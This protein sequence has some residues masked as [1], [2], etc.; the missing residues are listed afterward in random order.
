[1]QDIRQVLDHHGLSCYT[2]AYV[3]GPDEEIYLISLFGS[4]SRVQAVRA[5]ILG[6]YPVYIQELGNLSWDSRKKAQRFT[7][8]K[9]QVWNRKLG[10]DVVHT[11]ALAPAVLSPE[12]PSGE[13][14]WLGYKVFYGTEAEVK[15]K[16]F[17]AAQQHY[18]TPL[19][20]QWT[21]WLW[22]AMTVETLDSLGFAQAYRVN[23][24]DQD[25]LERRLF[26]YGAP[27]YRAA[28]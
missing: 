20:P 15:E 17:Y 6:S 13:A 16:F 27:L 12:P 2:D 21:D 26:E 18:S 22:E 9:M 1:M 10:P 3:I 5:A 25:V 23:F 28:N 11:L 8:G 24:I 7:E 19:L 14:R 4:S